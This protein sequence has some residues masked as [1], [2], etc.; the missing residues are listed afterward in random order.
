MNTARLNPLAEQYL[1]RL[2]AAARVLPTPDREELV[3]EVRGHLEAGLAGDASDAD[4]R[5]LLDDLGSPADI[6]AAAAPD[7]GAA[8][9]PGQDRPGPTT[10]GWGVVEI[11][12][13]LGLT[14]GTFL[15]PVVG[16]VAGICLAWASPRWTN[17]EKSVATVFTFLPLVI[18]AIGAVVFLAAGP[19]TPALP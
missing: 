15:L 13:V 2:D 5:N 3:A 16:P 7:P 6:V 10:G 9:P 18:L 14:L 8:S 11:L 1:D 19:R 17:Q 4:V 12:A